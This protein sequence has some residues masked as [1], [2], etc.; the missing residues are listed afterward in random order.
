MRQAPE[1][2]DVDHTQLEDVLRR[3]EQALDAKDSK[4]IRAVFASYAYVADLVEDKNTSI[5]RLRQSVDA[6]AEIGRGHGHQDLH[7]GRE[8]Q[9]QSAFHKRRAR[10]STAAAS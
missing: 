5:A 3:A 8:L 1:I 2:I 9:H 10:A 7:L 6:A 4:L